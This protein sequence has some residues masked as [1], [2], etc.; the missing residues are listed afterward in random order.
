MSTP[1][2]PPRPEPSP[3]PQGASSAPEDGSPAPEGAS[4]APEGAAARPARFPRLRGS[5]ELGVCALLLAVG[6]LMLTDALTM[7]TVAS[8]RGP[9]GPRTVPVVVGAALVLVAVL[10]AVDVLRGGRG[11]AEGGEDVDLSEPGDWRTVALLAGVFLAFAALVGP[12]GFPLA[13]ALLFWGSAY[14]LGSRSHALT[15]DPLIAAG[16]SVATYAV[17]HLLLGVHLPG[18]PLMGVL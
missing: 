10:L 2:P 5:S 8:V 15:R 13:G 16:L 11:E 17:F 1:E 6:V 18:G 14:A 7:D 4:P 3:A 12:L 9:V